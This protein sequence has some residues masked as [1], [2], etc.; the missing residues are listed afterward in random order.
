MWR[1]IPVLAVGL[2]VFAFPGQAQVSLKGGI[3]LTDFVGGDVGDTESARGLNLGASFGLLEVSR[4][5]LQAEVFY[6][7][8]GAAGDLA[9][10]QALALS[11]PEALESFSSVEVGL[12][13]VEIPVLARV[14]LGSRGKSWNPYVFGGPAFGW[15]VSCGVTLTSG[16]DATSDCSDLS[17]N[18]EET[19]RAY[20]TGWVV[21]GGLDVLIPHSLGALTLDARYTG[22]LSTVGEG[23][24]A[25]D[26]RN[27][28]F[29][30]MLGYAF[31][32]PR[33][34]LPR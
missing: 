4:F 25:L 19:L 3:N 22:G 5:Q 6:R 33:F 12:D 14:N 18:L 16:E 32:P 20:E 34:M 17:E 30:V 29:T 2:C 28:A 31:R 26:I 13:Y 24:D 10:L 23:A 11:D 27:Q 15:R 21:G 1:S 9:D 8:K 7:Q